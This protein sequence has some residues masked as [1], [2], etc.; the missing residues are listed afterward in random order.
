[1]Y[2]AMH[3]FSLEGKVCS[4]AKVITVLAYLWFPEVRFCLEKTVQKSIPF[5]SGQRH[6]CT[7]ILRKE[8]KNW[9]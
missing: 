2:S 3:L 1:M 5:S 8:E 7:K 4:T 6:L 9:R